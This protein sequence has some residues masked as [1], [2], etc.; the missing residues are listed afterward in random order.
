MSNIKKIFQFL[1]IKRSMKVLIDDQRTTSL[2]SRTDARNNLGLSS[3]FCSVREEWKEK[4]SG[5]L[6]FSS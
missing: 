4:L 5:F 3:C 2:K 6:H 1:R